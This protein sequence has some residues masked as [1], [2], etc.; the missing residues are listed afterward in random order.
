MRSYIMKTLMVAEMAD[1]MQY[2]TDA[3]CNRIILACNTSHLFLPKIYSRVPQLEDN[4]VNIIDNC[5]EKIRE[6]NISKVFLLGSEVTI[7]Y[8]VYQKKLGKFNIECEVS[9][10]DEYVLLRNCI[11]AVKQN[12]YTDEIKKYLLVWL[13]NTIHTF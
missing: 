3:R 6:D 2:L 7:E 5:V 8:K 9:D 11:E 12:V 4:V 13:E 1:S 10:P